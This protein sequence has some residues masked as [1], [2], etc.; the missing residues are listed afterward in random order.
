MGI[1]KIILLFEIPIG[2]KNKSQ[3]L[4]L[5]YVIFLKYPDKIKTISFSDRSL[6]N[7]SY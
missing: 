5:Y 4:V 7:Y 1:L 2:N 6:S 3:T